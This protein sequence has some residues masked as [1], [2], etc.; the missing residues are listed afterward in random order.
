M[1]RISIRQ[2]STCPLFSGIT[3]FNFLYSCIPSKIKICQK[4]ESS[5]LLEGTSRMLAIVLSGAVQYNQKRYEKDEVLGE[6]FAFTGNSSSDFLAL[7]PSKIIL[8][9]AQK[10][11]TLCRT[12]CESHLRL[13]DNLMKIL[14]D[15]LELSAARNDLLAIH[16]IRSRLCAYLL[17]QR[18]RSGSDM[19]MLPMSRRETAE[20]LALSRPSMSRELAFLK[21]MGVLDYYRNTIHI[22][23]PIRLKSFYKS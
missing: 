19:L 5:P 6:I 11:M 21:N 7:K 15:R 13:K 22:I 18:S 3:D 23:D 20:F 9:P 8:L 1:N 4:G 10:I 16:G 2:L 12:C 14:L 17:W